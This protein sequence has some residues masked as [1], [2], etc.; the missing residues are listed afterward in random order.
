MM[1]WMMVGGRELYEAD[2]GYTRDN[3]YRQLAVR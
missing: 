1:S 2:D 3:A